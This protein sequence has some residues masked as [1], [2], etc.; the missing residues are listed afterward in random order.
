MDNKK[1]VF[2]QYKDSIPVSVN[3]YIA[4]YGF[5]KMGYEITHFKEEDI[6]ELEK[7]PDQLIYL[8]Y[9]HG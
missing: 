2:I 4:E 9:S 6:S 1:H 7:T 5:K 8:T 3:T